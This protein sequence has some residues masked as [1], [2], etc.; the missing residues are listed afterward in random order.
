MTSSWYHVTSLGHNELNA[1]HASCDF[2]TLLYIFLW[3]SLATRNYGCHFKW[4]IF[5][6]KSVI[7]ILKISCIINC[8]QVLWIQS[9]GLVHTNDDQILWWYSITGPQW[10][11]HHIISSVFYLLALITELKKAYHFQMSMILIQS[12]PIPTCLCSPPRPS[13][14]EEIFSK[15]ACH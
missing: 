11:K 4:V 3:D 5:P 7:H 15:F 1:L 10:V 2:F 8:S 9:I 14:A 13:E 6:N 12:A